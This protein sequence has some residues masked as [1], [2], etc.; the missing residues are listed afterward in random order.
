MK[1][2]KTNDIV[3]HCLIETTA[4]KGCYVSVQNLTLLYEED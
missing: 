2:K 4:G 1:L 3:R